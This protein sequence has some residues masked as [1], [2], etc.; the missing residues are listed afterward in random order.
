[1]PH[2]FVSAMPQDQA[3]V[4]EIRLT[5]EKSY[6]NLQISVATTLT[7]A[8][9]QAEIAR[10]NLFIYLSSPQAQASPQRQAELATAARLNIPLHRLIVREAAGAPDQARSRSAVPGGEATDQRV[11]DLTSRPES[12]RALFG[13]YSAINQDLRSK[14]ALPPMP[15]APAPEPTAWAEDEADEVSEERE[16][17]PAEKEIEDALKSAPP[18]PP[19]VARPPAPIKP[20]PRPS[21]P[22]PDRQPAPRKSRSRFPLLAVG[23][24]LL[25]L[26]LLAVLLLSSLS[27]TYNV[28]PTP[29]VSLTEPAQIT[30]GPG[31][32]ETVPM[33]FNPVLLVLSLL[34]IAGAGLVIWFNRGRGSSPAQAKPLVFISYRRDPSWGQARCITNSL[35]DRDIN[36]FFDVD[37]INEGKFAEVIKRAIENCDYFVPILA[38]VTLESEWV[39]QEIVYALQHQKPIIPLL[40]DGFEFD[41]HTLPAEVREIATHN[42]INVTHEFYDAAIER[43][44]TRFIRAS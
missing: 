28:L 25:V 34:L 2:I 3:L 17:S 42:A 13:F 16:E 22:E 31:V 19:A 36:V 21:Q 26:I 33:V 24:A 11:F 43:L 37:S 38:P 35:K 40:V 1:M 44:T 6:D 10:A 39:R 15:A 9:V 30:P 29:S 12:N 5:L 23:L 4:D 14:P 20:M 18:P 41:D 27:T 8:A 32:E 7:E